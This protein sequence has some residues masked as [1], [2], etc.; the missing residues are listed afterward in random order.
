MYPNNHVFKKPKQINNPKTN[1]KIPT[2][3]PIPPTNNLQMEGKAKQQFYA[4][5]KRLLKPQKRL[6][7]MSKPT[8]FKTGSPCQTYGFVIQNGYS[9]YR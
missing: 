9:M 3:I 7:L 2:I 6:D 1:K 5:S 4:S 8:E